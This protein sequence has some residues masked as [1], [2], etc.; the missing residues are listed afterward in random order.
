[1]TTALTHSERRELT[2]ARVAQARMSSE[3]MSLAMTR[4]ARSP[5]AQS[6]LED[7]AT[8]GQGY[9]AASRGRLE[10]GREPSGGSA[11]RHLSTFDRAK[12]R[13]RC[14]QLLRNDFIAKNLVSGVEALVIGD[15]P[16]FRIGSAD[17]RFNKAA[18]ALLNAWARGPVD[19]RQSVDLAGLLGDCVA[20]CCSDG[21]GCLLPL[22]TGRNDRAAVQFIE[23]ERIV[24]PNGRGNDREHVNG[25]TFDSRN[26][27]RLVNIAEWEDGG[28]YP[29]V[30]NTVAR[31]VAD[32]VLFNNPL[33]QAPNV[34]A[35]PPALHPIVHT[36]ELVHDTSDSV[37]TSYYIATLFSIIRKVV[38]PDAYQA[39]L[40]DTITDER[41]ETQ[42]VRDLM[43]GI[44][45]TM[46]ANESIE[47]VKP[48]HPTTQWQEFAWTQLQLV[49]ASLGLPPEIAYYRFLKNFSASK[50]ALALSHRR[51]A[52][53]RTMVRT[54]SLRL[55]RWRLATAVRAGE[56]IDDNGAVLD[57]RSMPPIGWDR[58]ECVLPGQPVIDLNDEIEGL[59]RGYGL[60]L[61]THDAM[62]HRANPGADPDEIIEA[63]SRE[64][65]KMR[66]L[67]VL[68]EGRDG[69]LLIGD[70]TI[71]ES[72]A[73]KIE[74]G[75]LDADTALGLL[76]ETIGLTKRAAR[77]IV[78]PARRAYEKRLAEAQ[79]NEDDD[80]E[81]TDED[82]SALDAA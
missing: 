8:Y 72:I 61:W 14:Q 5:V 52:K 41:G 79:E 17:K 36:L 82:A 26:R 12:M 33:T 49:A 28:W 56:L 10:P 70:K 48:E 7:R 38:E 74:A 45:E 44:E 9:D 51:L 47:Q 31:P 6:C 42:K 60:N 39:M 15:G 34:T 20:A 25:I 35:A 13:R 58:I 23:D 81:D 53:W 22:K 75:E 66:R 55:A 21:R 73:T 63:R 67:G 11:D 46:G 62:V 57:E 37:S 80:A 2:R 76:V 78:E 4:L 64:I 3:L 19:D 24:N 77:S 29:R 68:E 16:R 27:P 54:I 59:E 32:V 1:M 40:D 50:G 71:A 69:G 65:E 30:A 18:Q 43:A